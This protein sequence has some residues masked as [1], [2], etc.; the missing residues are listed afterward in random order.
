VIG[1]VEHPAAQRANSNVASHDFMLTPS[2]R[3]MDRHI[4][5]LTVDA[6]AEPWRR[7]SATTI[8]S[9]QAAWRRLAPPT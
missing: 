5:A 8:R 4:A 9:K 3:L 2:M 1:V 7:Q 6:G